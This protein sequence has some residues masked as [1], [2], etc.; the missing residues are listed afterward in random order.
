[1]Y[2]F[3]AFYT[4]GAAPIEVHNAAPKA[5][6]AAMTDATGSATHPYDQLTPN[7][8]L[9]AVERLGHHCDAR[10]LPLNSYENRVYQVGIEQ[11]EPL[12]AKF[13]RPQR[14]SDRQILEEHAFSA[15]L[16]ALDIPVVPPLANGGGETL[17]CHCDF[18]FALFPRRGGRAPEL[19]NPD[20]LEILGRYLGRIHAAGKT[21][22]FRHRPTIDVQSYAVDSFQLLR[23]S[24]FVPMEL[25]TAYRTL[26]EDLIA[27]LQALFG[28][29]N[30]NS[31]RLHGDCHPGNILW[32]DQLPHFVDFDDCRNGPAIQDLWMLLSGD[33]RQQTGQLDALLRG[34]RQFCD[35][36]PA[37]LPLIEGLRTLRIMHYA[38]WL[39]RRWHDPAFPQA[40]PWFNTARYW[41]EH[42]LELREQMAALQEPA[43][44]LSP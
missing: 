19:D 20:N 17:F 12:I 33:R 13:Y 40:F 29:V 11:A 30:Y 44:S 8:V 32:R 5:A 1:M 38:A 6:A 28:G 14:W 31:I 2:C 10:I 4:V 15:E 9:D 27:R 42:I 37:E 43:L 26:A 3:S 21:A 25:A 7:R 16:A 23:G 24:D 36:D 22:P 18:R 41:G 34:Y 39:A 35:F